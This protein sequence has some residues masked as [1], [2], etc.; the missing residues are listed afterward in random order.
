MWTK[1]ASQECPRCHYI[2]HLNRSRIL[3]CCRACG[4]TSHADR[5]GAINIT[6]RQSCDV[7]TASLP[8]IVYP[9]REGLSDTAPN[10]RVART[11]N[12]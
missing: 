7:I 12:G 2:N 5:V 1:Y 3:F 8:E 6:N 9:S 11:G 10:L 4:H